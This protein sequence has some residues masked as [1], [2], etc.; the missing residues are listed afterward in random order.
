[1]PSLYSRRVQKNKAEAFIVNL[2]AFI[3]VAVFNAAFI[4]WEAF[5]WD[6]PLPFWKALVG[7]AVII[8]IVKFGDSIDRQ[9]CGNLCRYIVFAGIAWVCIHAVLKLIASN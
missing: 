8:F 1:M 6:K 9:V 3:I 5:L 7:G 2:L 4:H